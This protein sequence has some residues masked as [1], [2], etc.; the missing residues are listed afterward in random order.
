MW[1]K[2]QFF[3][4]HRRQVC[5]CTCVSRKAYIIITTTIS[6]STLTFIR[7]D[8]TDRVG[9]NR[10][11]EALM[12]VVKWNA[13]RNELVSISKHICPNLQPHQ[14]MHTMCKSTCTCKNE[15]RGDVPFLCVHRRIHWQRRKRLEPAPRA[16]SGV[17]CPRI[18]LI[19]R[20]VMVSSSSIALR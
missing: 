20:H 11:M 1:Y 18:S 9:C 12:S 7:L 16:Y 15:K 13:T 4:V 2:P 3:F 10:W 8:N 14:Y 19:H 6:V 17:R 5:C